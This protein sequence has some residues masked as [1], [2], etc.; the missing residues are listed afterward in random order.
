MKPEEKIIFELHK[1]PNKNRVFLDFLKRK[2]AKENQAKMISN[3]DLLKAY[4]N[5]VFLERITPSPE[6]ENFLRI[7]KIRS[8]SGIIIVSVLTKPYACPGKCLYCPSQRKVPKSYLKEEPA[9]A[10]A[11]ALKYSPYGQVTARLKAL[12]ETGHPTDKIDLRIIG[13]TWSYYPKKYQT[14]FIKECF[15]ACNNF[16]AKKKKNDKKILKREQ[17]KN[18]RAKNRIIGITVETRPDFIDEK[19]LINLRNLGVTRVELGIQS[20]YEDVLEK[21]NRGHG[22]KQI[23]T[24]T[25]LLK[26]AGFKIC[27]QMMPNLHGSSAKKDIKMFK[28]LFSNQ[29]FMPDYL[30]IYPCAVLKEAP[31]YELWKKKKYYPYNYDELLNLLKEIKKIVPWWC[32]IQ[33]IVR[34]I[35]AQYIP[36]GGVRIS[37]LRQILKK[38]QKE[39][40]WR[41]KCIRC[42]EVG[43]DYIPKE[44]MSLFK[45]VFTASLGKEFFLSFENKKRTKIFSLIRVRIPSQYYLKEKHFVSILD[46]SLLVR[47]IHT[48]GQMIPFAKRGQAPQHQGLGKKLMKIAEEI[49][50]KQAGIKKVAVIAGVGTRDYYR[51]LGYAL[52][53]SYMIKTIKKIN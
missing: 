16:S 30:K 25:R 2:S 41:C 22:L 17:I 24:A 7:R 31:L 52:K 5:L 9:V 4:H 33:R 20:I 18:E 3:S 8:L 34:D 38:N 35:P 51:K 15:R 21:N 19:E 48:Y 6:M 37:N 14:W 40:G 23:I 27:Y 43:A 53:E 46:D 47:E 50:R 13:G 39:E 28:T 10:R 26:D 45:E 49:A 36:E 32:R 44:K 11:I 1:K 12:K 29:D 42:R